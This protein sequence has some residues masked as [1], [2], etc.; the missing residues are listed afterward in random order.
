MEVRALSRDGIAARLDEIA[1][2]R[3]AV[4]REWPYLYDGDHGYERQYLKPYIESGAALV[5]GAFDGSRL[6]GISTATPMEDHAAEFGA[7]FA[8]RPEPLTSIFYGG[9]SLLLPDYRGRG[10]GQRFFDHREARAR[11]LGRSHVAFCSVT[12]PPDHPAK[13]AGARSNEAFWSRRGYAP[14]PGVVAQFEWRDTGD[15]LASP[16]LMQFWMRSLPEH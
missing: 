13:P 11:E 6:A 14:L 3:I 8:G 16:H 7:A 10:I 1:A 15:D 4:F 2:L 9:E 5:V 12:R